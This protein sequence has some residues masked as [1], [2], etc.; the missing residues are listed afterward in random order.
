MDNEEINNLLIRFF[1]QLFK[2][3]INYQFITF[4]I[5]IILHKNQ[6]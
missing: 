3:K 2:I 5:N 6:N 1:K 4:F